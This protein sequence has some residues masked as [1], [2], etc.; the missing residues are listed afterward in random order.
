MIRSIFKSNHLKTVNE[1]YFQHMKNSFS[2]SLLF[3]K[4]SA[5]LIIHG[6][7]PEKYKTAGTDTANII[8]NSIKNRKN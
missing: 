6:L 4:T 1:T 5:K 7:H 3:L 2:Y 8:L